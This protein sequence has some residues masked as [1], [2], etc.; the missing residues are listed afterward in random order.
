MRFAATLCLA[1]LIVTATSLAVPLE[2]DL[3]KGLVYCRIAESTPGLPAVTH[4]GSTV[5][6]LRYTGTSAVAP[7]DLKNW[8]TQHATQR[9]PVFVL[10]NANTAVDLRAVLAQLTAHTRLLVIGPASAS[11]QPDI[12]IPIS[13]EAEQAAYFELQADTDIATL[14][15]PIAVKTRH[16]EAAIMEARDRGEYLEEETEPEL[17][18]DE[19]NNTAAPTIDLALQRAVH[20]HRTWLI[21]GTPKP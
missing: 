19:A 4:N 5:L 9:S 21:L 17:T 16:D 6:D 7:K 15:T 14:I 13:A 2:R 20:L 10:A 1:L 12:A 8:L 3:G 11:F 18:D